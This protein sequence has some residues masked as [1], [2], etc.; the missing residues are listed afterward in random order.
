MNK[1]KPPLKPFLIEWCIIVNEETY[2]KTPRATSES[3]RF[4]NA[5]SSHRRDVVIACQCG[6]SAGLCLGFPAGIIF[7]LFLLQNSIPSVLIQTAQNLF[8]DHISPSRIALLLGTVT[9]SFLFGRII[10][11][12]QSWRLGLAITAGVFIG[13][14]PIMNSRLDLMIQ[15]FAFPVHIRFGLVLCGTVLNVMLCTGLLLGFV[16]RNW[17]ASVLLAG[18]SGLTSVLATLLVFILMDQ[19]GIRVGSGNFA[20]LKVTAMGIMTA[21]IIGGATL[22]VVFGRYVRRET[23]YPNILMPSY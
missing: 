5:P 21:A 16:L 13:Q 8:Q 3:H 1:E 12:R 6:L 20:M 7:W 18:S 22:G 19:F 9:W 2:L 17:K 23:L 4:P 14:W 10:D 11:Y 15:R